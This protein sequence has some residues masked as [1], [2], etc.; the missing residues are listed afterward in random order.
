MVARDRRGIGA[1][2]APWQEP[3]QEQA[4]VVSR[5]QLLA[6]GM[7]PGA[8]D[9]RLEA[10]R[11]VRLHHGVYVTFTGPVPVVGRVW[12]ALLACGDEA[13]LAGRSALWLWGVIETDEPVVTVC[14]PARR[15][16]AA[17]RSE[18]RLHRPHVLRQRFWQ[19][20]GRPRC[21]CLKREQTEREYPTC[22]HRTL[23]SGEHLISRLAQAP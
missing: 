10:G 18:A 15:K 3:A 9:A 6:R 13:A 4:G 16:I 8:I 17:P 7:T 5:A 1:S 21:A 22:E 2:Q 11:W 23:L 12:A 19:Q 14:V 20:P